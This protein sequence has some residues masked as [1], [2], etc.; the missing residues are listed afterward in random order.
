MH[1]YLKQTK[2]TQKALCTLRLL[3]FAA[4]VSS[5]TALAGSVAVPNSF[6]AN[7][8]AVAAEV[9]ANFNAV[10]TAVDDND[11]RIATLETTISNL[12]ATVSS[13]QATITSQA[14]TI[15][16]LQATVTS[17]DTTISNLQTTVASLQNNS[18]L[19]LDGKLQ[20]VTDVDGNATAQFS[21]V[22]VQ[23]INGVDQATVN[24]LGNLIIGYNAARTLGGAVCSDGQYVLQADCEAAGEIWAVSHKSGSH[25]LVGGDQNSYSATGGLILGVSNV[26]NRD[27]AVVSGG[28]S[29]TASGLNSSVS[30]GADNTASGDSSSISGG[31]NSLASG[32]NSS[33]SGGFGNTASGI[34]S[35][36][37]GGANN[38]ASGT[39]SSVSGGASRTASGVDNWAA[40]S[41]FEVQ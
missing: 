38:I 22:N 2:R 27:Y 26:I 40:G 1:L 41:L 18:V 5:Q 12:Q 21:G 15:S 20:L 24:G 3:G 7:T 29:N 13:L 39:Q 33:V 4:L 8:P 34:Q 11:S 28:V 31:Q 23:V 19:A 16:D 14:T 32:A 10:K 25:N 36:V 9:N 37:S 6:S 17:Q 35:S 30:G